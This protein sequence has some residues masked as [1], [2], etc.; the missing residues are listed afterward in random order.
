[1]FDACLSPDKL[2]VC[3]QEKEA[4]MDG[5]VLKTLNNF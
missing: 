4:E 3:I 1:M 5:I 2:N